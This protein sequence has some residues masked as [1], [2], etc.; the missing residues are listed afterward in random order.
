MV[1][2]ATVFLTALL[3]LFFYLPDVEAQTPQVWTYDFGDGT[4]TFTSGD[5][6]N[7]ALLPALQTDGGDLRLR[8][9]GGNDIILSETGN[10]IGTFSRMILEASPTGG[11]N[12][13]ELIQ[14]ND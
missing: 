9:G 8:I 7:P 10:D 6:I 13:F 4:G 3:F 12:I 14:S 1:K 11:L 5:V 2:N